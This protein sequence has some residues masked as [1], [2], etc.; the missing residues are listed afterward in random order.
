MLFGMSDQQ[1]QAEFQA[2]IE[3]YEAQLAEAKTKA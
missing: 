3:V 1:R 2:V